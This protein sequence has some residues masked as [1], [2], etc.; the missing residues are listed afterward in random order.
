MV[1]FTSIKSFALIGFCE[2]GQRMVGSGFSNFVFLADGV[3][4]GSQKLGKTLS[5]PL[6][7]LEMLVLVPGV[8]TNQMSFH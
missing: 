7:I 2:M 3:C 5:F 4:D 6:A 1:N 8:A